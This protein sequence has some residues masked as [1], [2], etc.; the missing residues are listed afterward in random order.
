MLFSI[1]I[2]CYNVEQYVKKCLDSIYTQ[3]YDEN[4]FEIIIVDDESPDAFLL[5]AKDYL[6]G[7]SNYKIISQ[8]NKGL[9]GARNT[10]IDNASG[11]YLI[12]L[13][14]DD[15][16]LDKSLLSL[17]SVISS[18]D[19]IEFSYALTKENQ[20]IGK[21]LFD[22]SKVE[23]GVKYFLTNKS[24]NSACNKIYRREFL[25]AN[26]LRFVEKIYGED[27]EFNTRAIFFAKKV[28]SIGNKLIAFEQSEGSITRNRSFDAKIKYLNDLENMI[29]N[30]KDFI[31]QHSS[32]SS[33]EELNYLYYR[34]CSMNVNTLLFAINNKIPKDIIQNYIF[35]LKS[36]NAFYFA[37]QLYTRDIYRKVFKSEITLKLLLLIRKFI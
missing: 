6:Q 36:K 22:D 18:E 35:R 9:G 13:D 24:V 37:T 19:I 30:H 25:N 29:I 1:I 8:K 27:I 23:T 7:K 21:Y 17:S 15:A 32:V 10:G 3:N 12:F 4:L 5:L 34:L 2:P 33:E 31:D 20:E 11:D 28:K 26:N 16:L 14:A